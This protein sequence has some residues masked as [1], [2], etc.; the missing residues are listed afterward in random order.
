M[1]AFPLAATVIAA[2][3]AFR[4]GTAAHKRGNP[5]LGIWSF[6]LAQFTVAAAAMTLGVAFGWTPVMYRVFYLFGAVLNVAWLG[7]GTIWLLAGRALRWAAAAALV[8]ASVY[9]CAVVIGSDL[10]VGALDEAMPVP[11]DVV[12]A[13]VRVLSRWF[14]IG[15]SVVV[16]AG[17][18]VSMLSRRRAQAAALALLAAGVVVVGLAGEMARVG[19]AGAFSALL[20]G[21]IAVMFLGF[22]R[23]G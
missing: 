14:S 7:L 17:L 10:M 1:A 22:V 5:A 8:I 9:A 6:A 20:A 19:R 18:V 16:V 3:F 13:G 23:S 11:A 15:G 2:Y 12:A 21:G 4:T